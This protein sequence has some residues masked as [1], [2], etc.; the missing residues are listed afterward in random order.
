MPNYDITSASKLEDIK[1]NTC[2]LAFDDLNI[3][4]LFLEDTN[5][6][7]NG[8]LT[9]LKKDPQAGE[10]FNDYENN[11]AIHAHSHVEGEGNV[12]TAPHQH[13]QG[14]YNDKT[15]T[16]KHLVH[17]VGW[18]E[19]DSQRKNIHTIDKDGNAVFTGV[20]TAKSVEITGGNNEDG[21]VPKTYFGKNVPDNSIGKPGDIYC[22]II[23][24]SEN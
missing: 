1:N 5:T 8:I 16:E 20:V 21:Y 11:E 7:K 6:Y 3:Y 13:V 23:E 10:I 2:L 18:G 15:A 17:I 24:E 9:G 14:K 12:S 4:R 22:M 19:S